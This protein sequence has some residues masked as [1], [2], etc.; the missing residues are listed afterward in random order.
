MKRARAQNFSQLEYYFATYLLNLFGTHLLFLTCCWCLFFFFLFFLRRCTLCTSNLETVAHREITNKFPYFSGEC[1]SVCC[2]VIAIAHSVHKWLVKSG[3]ERKESW[4]AIIFLRWV[5]FSVLGLCMAALFICD[6]RKIESLYAAHSTIPIGGKYECDKLDKNLQRQTLILF[7]RFGES[8]IWV[9]SSDSMFGLVWFGFVSFTV[10]VSMR[11]CS[12]VSIQILIRIVHSVLSTSNIYRKNECEEKCIVLFVG[13]ISCLC[14]WVQCN[15]DAVSWRQNFR[16]KRSDNNGVCFFSFH[17]QLQ[18][19]LWWKS[20]E[21]NTRGCEWGSCE[22][23]RCREKHIKFINYKEKKSRFVSELKKPQPQYGRSW[24]YH[25]F[26]WVWET[27][28]ENWPIA[29][30]SSRVVIVRCARP[31]CNWNMCF[32]S[33]ILQME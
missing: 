21:A 7:F 2:N 8:E 23:D 29:T 3:K 16:Y 30:I 4:R 17:N 25:G 15:D 20:H 26:R 31:P 6:V 11:S 18:M 33:F 32:A 9:N 19:C 22:W 12:C 5:L 27:K 10:F 14:V 1:V 28:I 13:N 24:W